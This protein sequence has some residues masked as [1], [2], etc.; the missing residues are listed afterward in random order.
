MEVK[1]ERTLEKR[2]QLRNMK[3]SNSDFRMSV[4]SHTFDLPLLL[5]TCGIW[6]SPALLEWGHARSSCSSEGAEW[7]VVWGLSQ[8]VE[9]AW[10]GCSQHL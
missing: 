6:F 7:Q 1:Q 8:I 4:L 10:T 9:E 2:N 3:R 5:P